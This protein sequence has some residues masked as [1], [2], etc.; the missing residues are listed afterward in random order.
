MIRVT[1]RGLKQTAT[2]WTVTPNGYGG[3]TFGTPTTLK[4]RWEE[5]NE[6][7]IGPVD[8]REHISQSVVFTDTDL[9]VGDYLCLGDKTA[10]ADPTSIPEADK[11]QKFN[12]ITD[13]QNIAVIRRAML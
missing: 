1:T 5:R 3:D 13:L 7:F 10:T 6:T 8:R 4:C 9:A 2:R 12:R 11:V